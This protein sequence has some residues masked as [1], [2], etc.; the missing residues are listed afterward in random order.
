MTTQLYREIRARQ[1]CNCSKR[2]GRE[3]KKICT[4]FLFSI[5]SIK[6]LHKK[7]L[8]LQKQK[9]HS[10]INSAERIL[11]TICKISLHNLY[12]H[13]ISTEK[14]YLSNLRIN[15]RRFNKVVSVKNASKI[16][17]RSTFLYHFFPGILRL[18]NCKLARTSQSFCQR[19]IIKSRKKKKQ[20]YFNILLF[21]LAVKFR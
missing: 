14:G 7:Y 6:L 16:F 8:S 1:K 3:I 4:Y 9:E 18:Q 20:T 12:T 11:R 5:L 21:S 17:N 10:K 15:S 2:T 13:C 19:T